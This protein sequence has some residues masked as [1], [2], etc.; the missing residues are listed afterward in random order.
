MKVAVINVTTD[1]L[2]A[3]LRDWITQHP[4]AR[5]GGQ[6]QSSAARPDGTVLVTVVLWYQ[7]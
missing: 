3:A 6:T 5:L 7:E 4:R 1:E 2:E